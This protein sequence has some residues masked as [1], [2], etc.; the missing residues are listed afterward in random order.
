MYGVIVFFVKVAILLQYLKIFAPIR[1]VNQVMYF[2]A[3][4]L[5]VIHF[6]YYTTVESFTIWACTPREKIWNPLIE[7]DKCRHDRLVVAQATAC[8]NIASDTIIL[9]L[10]SWTIWKLHIPL[11]RKIAL[12]SVFAMGLL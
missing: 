10:P 4:A 11:K 9:L 12:I 3:W 1:Q 6:T 5:I 8:F 2:G 7:G